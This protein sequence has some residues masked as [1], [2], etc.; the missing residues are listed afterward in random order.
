MITI[1]DYAASKKISY[2]AVRKQLKR[3]EIE[4]DGHIQQINRTKFLDDYAVEF[5][6]EKRNGNP[7]V[8]LE[9]SKDEEIER[10]RNEN[11]ALLLKITTLQDELM[12]EKDFGKELLMEKTALLQE[13]AELLLEQ[14]NQAA[15]EKEQRKKWWKIW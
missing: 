4:L 5:L 3:Y 2:E 14:K 8:I 12:K 6:D 9:A 7:V 10:L 13:R 15:A 11:K 1:K